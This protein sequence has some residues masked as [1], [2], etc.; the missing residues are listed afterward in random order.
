MGL[1]EN[2]IIC[3]IDNDHK[4]QGKRLYG[5]NLIVHSVNCLSNESNPIVV[6]RC[7]PYSEE[8]KSSLLNVNPTIKF[9]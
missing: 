4:K 2:N 7:G 3:I 5:T 6:V 1:S 8:I 9:I